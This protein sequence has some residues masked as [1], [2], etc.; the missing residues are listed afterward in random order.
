ME[1]SYD[2]HE[3]AVKANK[4]CVLLVTLNEGDRFI[5]Q[6]KD[7]K[8]MSKL[9]DLIVVDGPSSD[10][11]TN[12]E[13]LK[14]NSVRAHLTTSKLGL[15]LTLRMG[16]DYA[17]NQDY[18]GIITID[19]NGKDDVNQIPNFI[20][21]L[22]LG[23]DLVQA[24]RFIKG[25]NH[26][27]TPIDRQFGIRFILSPLISLFSG[28][29]LTDVTNGFRALSMRFIKDNRVQLLRKEFVRFN[30]QHYIVYRAAKLKF[31]IKEL[32]VNRSYPSDGSVPSKIQSW[33][34]KWLILKEG[35]KTVIGHYNP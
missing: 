28:I 25:G 3:F 14:E 5:K 31:E 9:V 20:K 16:I 32:P 4:Y 2:I 7:M 33:K 11:S 26:K 24:S 34:T 19:T 29:W 23:F 13:F 10:N 18:Q 6:L 35:I 8:E 30:L 1:F 21:E 17:I 27:N 12:E 22:E 15:G